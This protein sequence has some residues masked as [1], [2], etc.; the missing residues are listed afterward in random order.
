MLK[1]AEK[2]AGVE[3]ISGRGFHGVKR[4]VV[5]ELMDEFGGDAS[6]VG[7]ITGNIESSLLEKTYRQHEDGVRIVA[8]KALEARRKSKSTNNPQK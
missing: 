5:T 1:K 6:A 4:R 8:A 2:L 3:H 7:S